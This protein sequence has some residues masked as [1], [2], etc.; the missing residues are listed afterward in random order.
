MNVKVLALILTV[1]VTG[2]NFAHAAEEPK[3]K[4]DPRIDQLLEQNAQILKNQAE[5]KQQ[6]EKLSQEIL[7]LRR[8]SS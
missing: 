2:L 4:A 5:I 6:L 3:T 8:R 1:A 7:Q